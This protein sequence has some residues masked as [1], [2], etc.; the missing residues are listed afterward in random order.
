MNR[1]HFI[2]QLAGGLFFS[3]MA[4]LYTKGIHHKKA[5]RKVLYYGHIRGTYYYDADQCTDILQPG[6]PLSITREKTNV[7]DYRAIALSYKNYKL[8]YIP[9]E[10]NK[11]LSNILD[12]GIT[13]IEAEVTQC[14]VFEHG[15]TDISFRLYAV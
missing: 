9:R 11:I 10:D 14:R 13:S 2:R 3:G 15:Y 12:H 7:H 6:T 5:V 8:G 1:I 4:S